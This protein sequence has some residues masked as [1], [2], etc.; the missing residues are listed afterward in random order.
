MT[1]ARRYRWLR[2][3]LPFV[4]VVAAVVAAALYLYV[5]PG[6]WRRATAAMGLALL[7]AC[8]LRIALPADRVG[9]LGV[10]GRWY[11][12]ACYFAMGALI[13][14]LDIRLH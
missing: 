2:S 1:V 7:G 9:L 13:L 12:A 10:R 5:F 8:A 14:G 6:H 11:D 4:F 3:E